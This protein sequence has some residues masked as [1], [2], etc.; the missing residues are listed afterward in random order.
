MANRIYA[1]KQPCPRDLGI[2][3]C[4]DCRE[5]YLKALSNVDF[6]IQPSGCGKVLGDL[7]CGETHMGYELCGSCKTAE[8]ESHP[9]A[10][11]FVVVGI[12]SG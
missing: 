11:E 6:P 2:F 3:Y 9:H 12:V 5:E 10:G 4:D 1:P 8:R 7:V